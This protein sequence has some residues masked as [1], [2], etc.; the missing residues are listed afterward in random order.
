[1]QQSKRSSRQNPPSP[2]ALG[3]IVLGGGYIVNALWMH[4][5]EIVLHVCGAAQCGSLT[6]ENKDTPQHQ[7]NSCSQ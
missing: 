1:M 4:L 7:K 3:Y 5:G 6:Q 2:K